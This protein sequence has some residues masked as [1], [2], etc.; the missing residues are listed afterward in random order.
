MGRLYFTWHGQPS[1][2]KSLLL[3]DILYSIGKSGKRFQVLAASYQ[4]AGP[5]ADVLIGPSEA[6]GSNDY[7]FLLRV[8]R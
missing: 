2:V 4:V 6:N 8:R 5:H 7:T 1:W 3:P